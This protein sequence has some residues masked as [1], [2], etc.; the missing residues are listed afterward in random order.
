M[1]GGAVSRIALMATVAALALTPLPGRAVSLSET[2]VDAIGRVV[3]AEAGNQPIAGKVAVI[4]TIL[5]RLSSGRFGSDL[6]SVIAQRNAFEPVTRAGGWRWLPPLT[7]NQR[8]ELD[9]ILALKAAGHLG[10]ISG[11]ALYFQNPRIVAD[12]AAAGRVRPD[13]VGFAGM[14]PTA[15]IGEHTF[16]R[17]AGAIAA[18]DAPREP[19]ARKAPASSAHPALRSS[20]VGEELTAGEGRDGETVLVPPADAMVEDV[21]AAR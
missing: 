5:N 14:P 3:F 21:A 13:L 17:P 7:L 6:Q 18:A 8:V 19:E 4:D 2:D 12:R 16:Y 9:T 15:V 20:F 10:D 1:D 11:G